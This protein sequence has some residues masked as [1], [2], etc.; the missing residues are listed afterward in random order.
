MNERAEVFIEFP[1]GQTLVGHEC[2][3]VVFV[4]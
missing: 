4:V 3:S 1:L 2:C